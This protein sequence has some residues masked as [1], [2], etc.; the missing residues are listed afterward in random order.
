MLKA[1]WPTNINKIE[2]WT[3][4]L[5]IHSM[6]ALTTSQCCADVVSLLQPCPQHTKG[7]GQSSA[8]FQLCLGRKESELGKTFPPY[9]LI[10]HTSMPLTLNFIQM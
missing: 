5:L 9:S 4:L 6:A 2:G 1:P 3:H 7:R 10:F 8:L